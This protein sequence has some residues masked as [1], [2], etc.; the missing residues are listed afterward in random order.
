MIRSRIRSQSRRRQPIRMPTMLEWQNPTQQF[1]H[2]LHRRRV[3]RLPSRGHQCRRIAVSTLRCWYVCVLGGVTVLQRLSRGRTPIFGRVGQ[4]QLQNLSFGND[5]DGF[6]MHRPSHH[7]VNPPTKR[8]GQ[9]S[10]SKHLGRTMVAP[11]FRGWRNCRCF[12][13]KIGL[14]CSS[15]GKQRFHKHSGGQ[16]HPVTHGNVLCSGSASL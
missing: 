8:V 16:L 2:G 1:S 11:K 6:R 9:D 3:S 15:V 7:H 10:K 12:E 5:V 14:P 13:F 4:Y